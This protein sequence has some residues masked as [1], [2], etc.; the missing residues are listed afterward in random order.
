[1]LIVLTT[2]VSIICFGGQL[3]LTVTN[4]VQCLICYPMIVLFIIY[5]LCRF[6]WSDQIVPVMLDRVKGESFLNP[7]DV[8]K[9]RDFNLFALIVVLVSVKHGMMISNF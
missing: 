1:M 6:S 2:A 9:M 4:T 5:I 8:A 3:A 7:F